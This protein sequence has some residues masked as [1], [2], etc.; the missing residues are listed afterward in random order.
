MDQVSSFLEQIK[1]SDNPMIYY[2]IAAIILLVAAIVLRSLIG[3]MIMVAG[4]AILVLFFLYATGHPLPKLDL[5]KL[6]LP[7]FSKLLPSTSSITSNSSNSSDSSS[8]QIK[9]LPIPM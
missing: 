6:N 9:K 2:I 8:D 7:D 1:A 4:A 5:E 3:T